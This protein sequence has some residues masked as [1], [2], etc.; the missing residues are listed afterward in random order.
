MGLTPEQIIAMNNQDISTAKFI[1]D[2]SQIP[3]ENALRQVQIAKSMEKV[4]SIPVDTPYG[5][6][7]MTVPEAV[8]YANKQ[9]SM[10]NLEANRAESLA[11]RQAMLAQTA[12]SNADRIE[13]GRE[14][15]AADKERA[16]SEREMKEAILIKDQKKDLNNVI[17]RYA[18]SK[19]DASPLPVVE[20]INTAPANVSSN[21]AH[22]SDG[23]AYIFEPSALNINVKGAPKITSKKDIIDLANKQGLTVDQ[24]IQAIIRKN[25]Q[26]DE[27]FQDSFNSRVT[28][29]RGS[30]GFFDD[31]IGGD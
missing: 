5:K 24:T 9:E 11:L 22:I 19:K 18:Q 12:A 17:S 23:E 30:K 13:L 6:V 1:A 10:K 8:D 27:T 15:L 21:L 3:L 7:V 2:A 25:S 31:A 29:L 4:P 28:K 20:A 14:R 16:A 26:L